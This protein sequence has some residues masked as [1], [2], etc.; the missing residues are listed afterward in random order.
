VSLSSIELF[1]GAGGLALGVERAGFNHIAVLERDPLACET[2]R[3]NTCWPLFESD[4]REFDYGSVQP[5]IDILCG[6][7]PCQPFSLGGKGRASLDLRDM[8]PESIRAVRAL[9][10]KAFLFEN[11][12]GL[13]RE[14]TGPYLEYV[15]LQ[16]RHPEISIL[17]SESLHDHLARLEKHET[18][19]SR[20]G[21]NYNIVIQCLDAADYG[22]PQRRE[23]VFIA[24]FRDDIEAEWSFPL[25][26]HSLDALL[27]SQWNSGSYWERHQL[28]KK[29]VPH[30]SRGQVRANSLRSA[31][32][33]LP[34][35]TVRDALIDLP[36][37]Q[38]NP[39]L[40][41]EYHQHQFIPGARTYV[42]HTGS[43]LDLP[44]KTLKAGVHGVPGGENM[45]VQPDGTV[46]YFSVR[47]CARLQTFPDN[48]IFNCS[49]GQ[50]VK[51]LGNAVPTTLAHIL[52][53]SIAKIL[54][55]IYPKK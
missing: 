38:K 37:P 2:L 47:E 51:Q 21:L 28:S 45:Q 5:S 10:P 23:R 12:K 16:L 11:V 17:S 19:G 40:A 32:N 54:K 34:W 1:A 53:D 6:G 4:V 44:A 43:L 48:Y 49:W 24:G 26:T 31:P 42:G 14:K 9:Q 33:A 36:D 18:S 15:R 3:A 50:A 55:S 20:S 41:R 46:R 29:F 8:F 52:A 27:W 25:P 39:R 7:P 13:M 35:L 22:V 30:H